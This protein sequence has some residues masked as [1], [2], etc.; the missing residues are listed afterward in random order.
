MGALARKDFASQ[1]KK[2]INWVKTM[3]D[4]WRNYRN[5][6]ENMGDIDL[7]LDN[8]ATISPLSLNYTVCR[9]LTEVKKLDGSDFPP[10]TL[11]E[12]VLALQFYLEMRGYSYHLIDDDMFRE[13]RF[14]LD[15][16]MKKRTILGLG[17]HVRQAQVITFA[18]EE[19]MWNL[20]VLGSNTPKKLIDTILYKVGL[21]CAL[22]A[23]KEH[24]SLRS[25][26]CDSQFKFKYDIDGQLYL[27][28]RED[29]GLKTNKGGLKHTKVLP[30]VVN[31]Y[32]DPNPD[33]CLVRL[34]QKYTSLLP[35]ER[36]CQALYLRPLARV[37]NSVWFCDAPV[38][39]NTLQNT[40]KRLCESAGLQGYYTN[41]SLRAA[42]ATRM[43]NADIPEQCI[44]EVTGHRSL[45][46]RSYKKT[47]V[48]M[49]RKASASIHSFVKR[50]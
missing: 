49:K 50:Y 3:F 39:I 20:G 42:C 9:F 4:E 35:T 21:C 47:S 41:H 14:T 23:G 16:L 43:Y 31:I 11:K 28:Y 1:T 48:G 13:I 26:G 24:R 30:K 45:A 6:D 18:D 25:I 38:G 40:V 34:M 12:I 10:K 17:N 27:E 7:D 44:Q 32:P 37:K 19:R 36:K 2:K 46:V 5:N 33:R 22:R 15:N 8:D 29:V